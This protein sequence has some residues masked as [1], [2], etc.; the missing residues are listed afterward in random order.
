MIQ[1]LARM[2]LPNLK[3][4]SPTNCR[5]CGFL[6]SDLDFVTRI[7]K[8]AFLAGI[9]ENLIFLVKFKQNYTH[10]IINI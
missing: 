2:T 8:F 10:I 7:Q 1:W 6:A 4:L 5:S 3:I 9:N